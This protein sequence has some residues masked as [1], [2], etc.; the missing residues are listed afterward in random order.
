[1]VKVMTFIGHLAGLSA[2]SLHAQYFEEYLYLSKYVE[3]LKIVT[4]NIAVEKLDL[5]SNIEVVKVPRIPIPKVY[6]ATKII[7]YSLAPIFKRGEVDVLYVRT[8]SPP[9]LNAILFSKIFV[10]L[11]SVLVLP[12]TRL[13]GHPSESRG[14]ERFYQW[15]LRRALKS[16]D[17]IV[18]YS[19][20]MLHE[21]MLYYPR[22]DVSKV[23]YLHNAVNTNRFALE[24]GVDEHLMELKKGRKIILYVGRIN[25]KKGVGDL[26]K[27]FVRVATEFPE[28]V[29]ILAGSG[30]EDFIQKL[31]S[32]VARYR[33]GEKVLFFGPV[34]NSNIPALLR[35]SDLFVYSSR[36][37][38]GIPRAIIEAMACG[39]P[40][41]ATR[42][43]GVPEAVIDGATGYLVEP[44]DIQGLAEKILYLLR[45]DQLATEIGKKARQHVIKE[46]SYEKVIPKIAEI[47]EKAATHQTLN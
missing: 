40:V 21:I 32:M 2:P 39:K 10:K 25:E 38:E 47:L 37:G 33:L 42:V 36:E 28:A 3:S 24:G 17:K 27:A 19:R 26:V 15:F 23:V 4:D 46:F 41:V 31:S 12:G 1:M 14:K 5:P 13:F 11:P 43:A 9:E 16:A 20:L 7:F 45:N 22:L 18:L 6:G 34:P 35:A 8:F 29:L 30:P 44:R